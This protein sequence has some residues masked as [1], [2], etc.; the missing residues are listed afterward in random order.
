MGYLNNYLKK[1]Y[2][3]EGAISFLSAID[4][5]AKTSKEIANSIVQELKDQRSFLKLIASENYSSLAVQLACANLL[6]DKYSEGSLNKRFYA[7]CDNVDRIEG[8]AVEELK[9]LFNATH[10]YVQPHSGSDAN[11]LAYW[12]IISEKVE[13]KEIEKLGKKSVDELSD[14]EYEKIRK[15]LISQKIM[16]MDLGSGGHL[17]HGYRRNISSKMMMAKSYFVDEKT[18][19]LD[20]KKLSDQVKR[21]KPLIL[22]AG[23]SSYPR[24]INFAKMKEIAKEN[25][26]VLMA[27]MAH[28]A[29][30]VAGKAIVGE[31]D[32]VKY[33][34]M[35]TSTTH[36]TL[37]GPRGGFIL[38]SDEYKDAV[39]KGCPLVLGG[40]IPNIIAAKAIGFIEANTK[41][42]QIYARKVIEN[43]KTMAQKFLSLNANVIT[44]GTDNHIILIDVFSSF[45]LTGR[46]AEN[47][48]RSAGITVNRNV[49]VKDKNGPWYTSAIRIGTPAI[50]TL[51]MGKKE[52]EKIATII[53]QIL[54]NAKPSSS[55]AKVQIDEKI[56]T[57]ARA[58]VKELL[59]KFPLYPELII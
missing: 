43:A 42:F 28:F 51:N 26:A 25:G 35:I 12:A 7:G 14:E 44:K 23:Y 4:Y 37:R 11:I 53:V 48:L 33:A 13:N 1:G 27:D 57:K 17:S 3:H 52:V 15:I 6:T 50:T 10:A 36:K 55:R 9:K 56:L 38:C 46:Q 34:D 54:K 58:Q 5:I 8:I 31:Y 47:V 18:H 32:P 22:I 24:L 39:D 16:G 19:L 49:I 41:D 45:S 40:P 21:E 20:Y 30:L 29:G 2:K 59:E